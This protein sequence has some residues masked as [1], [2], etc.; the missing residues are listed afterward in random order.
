MSLLAQR[1]KLVVFVMCVAMG[2]ARAETAPG[3]GEVIK[4]I[5]SALDAAYGKAK[6][7]DAA[8]AKLLQAAGVCERRGCSSDLHA[9]VYGY[10]AIVHWFFDPDHARAIRDLKMMRKI[11]A[12]EELD[13]EYATKALEQAWKTALV[14]GAPAAIGENKAKT[15]SA[16]D[17]KRPG[18]A[19]Q[20][21]EPEAQKVDEARKAA[22]ER[23]EAERRAAEEKKE[24]ARLTADEKKEAARKA[25]EDAR[26]AAEEKKEAARKAAEEKKEAKRKTVE[27]A[28][29]AAEEKKEAA[30]KAAEEKKAD[31]ARKAEETRLAELD[32]RLKSPPPL[33]ALVE[34]PF[35]AQAVGYPIP[36]RVKLP[37]PP[38][39][40][41]PE[42]VEVTKVVTEYVG[43]G[44]PSPVRMELKPAK[45]G[46]YEGVLPCELTAQEGE[47]TYYTTSFNKYEHIVAQSGSSS[48]PNKVQIRADL[49][50]ALPHFVGELPPRSCADSQPQ[51][52][53]AKTAPNCP[54]APGCKQSA[55]CE[56]AGCGSE[57]LAAAL[58]PAS[59]RGGGCAGCEVGRRAP[60]ESGS[61]V[62]LLFALVHTMRRLRSRNANINLPK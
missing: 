16:T 31:D 28:R 30:R 17:E 15:I 22:E 55:A 43:P 51:P 52:T 23:K 38:S 33:G 3:N 58:P 50:A 59:P 56:G 26:K 36:I 60:I 4:L 21:R 10:L 19:A 29:K 5:A 32:R 53:R 12:Q 49:A 9:S 62:G 35:K 61:T 47:V 46:S 13:S 18:T 39:G 41:E 11:D 25:A 37:P 7:I 2:S 54:G 8:E 34:A 1:T 42:R 44:V 45:G 24:A 48:S 40:I 14:E 6:K 57:T 20:P 27:D